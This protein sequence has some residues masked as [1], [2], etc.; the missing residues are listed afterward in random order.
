MPEVVWTLRD[1][2]WDAASGVVTRVDWQAGIE[3]S[4]ERVD[5]FGSTVFAM[6]P[7][8][9]DYVPLSDVTTGTVLSWV[10][11]TPEGV[12]VEADLH[13]QL[14]LRLHPEL[15]GMLPWESA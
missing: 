13:R 11:E 1:V 15:S 8:A 6:N 10:S 3:E 2:E 9:P 4:D 7:E 12:A 14:R 5:Q